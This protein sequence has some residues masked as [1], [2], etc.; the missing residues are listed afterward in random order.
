MRRLQV[1]RARGRGHRA[2]QVLHVRAARLREGRGLHPAVP[3]AR[4]RGRHDRAAQLRRGD[5]PLRP[6]DPAGGGR[7]GLER[8][9]DAR[10]AAPG[11]PPGRAGRGQV[12]PRPV[13]GHRRARHRPGPVVLDG[14]HLEQGRDARVRD[15]GVPR[16]PL[17]PLPRRAAGG[18]RPARADRPVRGLHA[19]RRRHRAAVRRR[20]RRDGPDPGPAPH[21]GRARHPAQGHVLLRRPG[22]ARPL[23]HRGAGARSPRSCPTSP[24]SRRCR[25]EGWSGE[26]GLIT[27]VVKRLATSAGGAH[28][29]VCGPPP[30]VEAAIPLL[31]DARR[32]DKRIYY[33]KFTTTGEPQ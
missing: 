9:G 17:L 16:R 23:L 33:D 12:L 26:T 6:A 15:Q 22:R 32:P 27:D 18:R 11:A 21:D 19:P 14:Q 29:Y 5:D 1:V 28:A 13:H 25:D 3:G 2:R 4:V 30:M 8:P 10:H 20:R 7:G 31:D 24:T